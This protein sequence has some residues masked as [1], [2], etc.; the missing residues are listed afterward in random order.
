MTLVAQQGI[1]EFD[2]EWF[3]IDGEIQR[4]FPCFSVGQLIRSWKECRVQVE[5]KPSEERTAEELSWFSLS[6][7]RHSI[8]SEEI[9]QSVERSRMDYESRRSFQVRR[10][11]RH[12][13]AI[14][15]VRA[16]NEEALRKAEEMKAAHR[17]LKE[18]KAEA[19]LKEKAARE[20][21]KNEVQLKM[22]KDLAARKEARAQAEAEKQTALVLEKE[23][24]K[25]ARAQAAAEAAR[26]KQAKAARLE[27][28]RQ[29][30]RDA[31][32][33]T[34]ALKAAARSLVTFV[35]ATKKLNHSP[36][37]KGAASKEKRA[38]S[39]EPQAARP[40]PPPKKAR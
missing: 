11:E 9:N 40:D 22:T 15:H 24:A 3:Q 32:H 19:R 25:A 12:V 2:K 23:A 39:A 16:A 6:I 8:H 37:A 38:N 31:K 1:F 35:K 27:A 17:K 36:A 7:S 28:E 18:E 29:A 10:Y 5:R 26:A 14:A 4:A 21:K 20:E 34:K 30:K 13:K 33:E